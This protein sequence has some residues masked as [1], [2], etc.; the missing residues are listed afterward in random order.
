MKKLLLLALTAIGLP[1]YALPTYEPFT[2]FSNTVA[3]TG[4]NMVAAVGG[5]PLGTTP[6]TGVAYSAASGGVFGGIDLAT[7]GLAAPTGES[8]TSLNFNGLNLTGTTNGAINGVNIAVIN[9]TNAVIFPASALSS[10][11]PA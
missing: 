7:G 3:T 1:A 5:V 9:D 4:S 11:L 6:T 8:W 10:L 2:E